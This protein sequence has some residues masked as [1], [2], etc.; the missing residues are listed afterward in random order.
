MYEKPADDPD[1]LS[2]LFRCDDDDEDQMA[3]S[4]LLSGVASATARLCA[5]RVVGSS[6]NPKVLNQPETFF[7]VFGRGSIVQEALHSRRILN[8]K[9]LCA[10][11]IRTLRPDGAPWNF[12]IKAHRHDARRTRHDLKPTWLVWSPP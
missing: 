3:D 10:M 5:A 7:D 9:G 4:Y 2:K 12:T 6:R 1:E 8:I 11:D